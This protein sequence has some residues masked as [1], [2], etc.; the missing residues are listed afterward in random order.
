[1]EYTIHNKLQKEVCDFIKNTQDRKLINPENLNSF[2][3]T[4]NKC[5]EWANLKHPRCKP[6]KPDWHEFRTGINNSRRDRRLIL[7]MITLE[8]YEADDN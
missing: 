1:M 6:L 8:I 4:I 3:E 7:P 5:I 2:I